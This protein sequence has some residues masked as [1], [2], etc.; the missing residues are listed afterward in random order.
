MQGRVH[1]VKGVGFASLVAFEVKL[2]IPCLEESLP[3][4][5]TLLIIPKRLAG[6]PSL[7]PAD[8]E[9]GK[10]LGVTAKALHYT[11]CKSLHFHM[12]RTW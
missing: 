4:P 7:I 3:L 12:A 5:I 9:Q 10:S 2:G 1:F 8:S 11:H 6:S